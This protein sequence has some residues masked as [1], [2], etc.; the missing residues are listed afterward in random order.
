MSTIHMFRWLIRQQRKAMGVSLLE[1]STR[2]YNKPNRPYI[3]QLENGRLDNAT[4]GTIDR[5]LMALNVEVDLVVDEVRYDSSL[6]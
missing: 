5:I 4:F 3:I 1:L 2:A 6:I